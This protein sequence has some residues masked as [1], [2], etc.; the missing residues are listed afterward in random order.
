MSGKGGKIKCVETLTAYLHD[1]KV[2]EVK[3][4]WMCIFVKILYNKGEGPWFKSLAMV[5]YHRDST[6]HCVH[7]LG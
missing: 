3:T 6:L 5:M 4:I 2:S 7:R 1:F